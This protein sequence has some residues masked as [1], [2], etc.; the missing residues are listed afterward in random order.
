MRQANYGQ[1]ATQMTLDL[2]NNNMN[3]NNPTLHTQ[4]RRM[5]DLFMVLYGSFRWDDVAAKTRVRD[6]AVRVNRRLQIP[7]Q[8]KM[9]MLP[10]LRIKS[11]RNGCYFPEWSDT[12]HGQLEFLL[13]RERMGPRP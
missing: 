12:E 4:Q 1:Q 13:R 11:S 9:P 10:I 2:I 8:H 5:I 7:I 3:N 6:R